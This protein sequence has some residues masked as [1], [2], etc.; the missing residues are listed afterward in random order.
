MAEHSEVL[1]LAAQI[2]SAHV[3]HN[4]VP[5]DQLPGLIRQVFNSLATAEQATTVPPKPE[6][7]VTIRQSVTA[8]HIVCLDC[9]KHFSMLKR[10]LMTDHKLTPEQYRQR[11][12]LPR[13]YP[14]V[15]PNYAKTRSALAKKIGL[16]RKGSAPRK[17]ERKA[18]R[19]AAARR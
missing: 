8:G 14:L 1:G 6:S 17:T 12:E 15:A 9:G 2:V 10:H 7:A 11:W 18:A 19:K 13:S 5:S 3:S 16:G 4:A